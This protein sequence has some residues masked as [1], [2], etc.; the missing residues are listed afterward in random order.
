MPS[1]QTLSSEEVYKTPWIRVRRDEVLNH[2]GKQVTY[3]IVELH[4]P[5]VC[6]IA[7]D[8]SGK[9]FLQQCYRYTIDKTDW[10]L[11]AG[12]S[13]GEDPLLAAKRELLEETGLTSDDWAHLGRLYQ[14]VGV[15]NMPMEVFLARNVRSA[16]SERDE[17]EEITKQQFVGIE[18]IE[19]MAR[20]G[21]FNNA[22]MLGMIYLAKLHG[23]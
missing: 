15:A 1:W 4:H 3:S 10:E 21:E 11:P 18:K 20:S 8:A 2:N 6:I 7:A 12:G 19:E 16:T 17:D 23:L 9:I 22:P 14:A 13:D 5:T